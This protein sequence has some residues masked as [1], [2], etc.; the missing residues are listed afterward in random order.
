MS[1]LPAVQNLHKQKVYRYT[2]DKF[3]KCIDTTVALTQGPLV[4]NCAS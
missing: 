1:F 4:S 2:F 3:T